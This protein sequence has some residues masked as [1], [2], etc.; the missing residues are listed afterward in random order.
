M[1]AAVNNLARDIAEWTSKGGIIDARALDAIRKNSVNAAVRDLLKGQDPSVQREAAASVMTRIKPALVNAI[2]DAGGVGYRQYLDDYTKKMQEIAQK[3][4]TGEA[5]R[6]WKTDKDAFVRLVQGESP[7]VVEK[8]LGKGN[9]NIAQELSE[10]TMQVLR[11]QAK[12]RLTE[13]KALEQADLGQVMLKELL[14]DNMPKWR[15]PSYL[16]ALVSSTN[17]AI[18]ILEDKIGKKTMQ[19]LTEGLKTPEG[20]IG[21][22]EKLPAV[23]KNRVLRLLN[24]PAEWTQPAKTA[25]TLGTVGTINALAPESESTNA[26]AP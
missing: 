7:E 20:A 3:K 26:L 17:K 5:L 9:Y 4:L 11:D 8:F 14:L 12:K 10:S 16:S 15:L 21:M 25:V 1:Q 24:N 22:L 18:G 2:E 6:L 19:S 13:T 23:E